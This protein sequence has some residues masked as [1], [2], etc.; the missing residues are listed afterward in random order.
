MQSFNDLVN[1]RR[2]LFYRY[3]GKRKAM[4]ETH[5]ILD[6]HTGIPPPAPPRCA[7]GTAIRIMADVLGVIQKK[8]H[9]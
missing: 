2:N 4:N 3:S 1:G 9:K 7:D 8:E 6:A 5:S